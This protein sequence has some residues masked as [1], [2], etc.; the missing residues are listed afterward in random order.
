MPTIDKEMNSIITDSIQIISIS[1]IKV[2]SEAKKMV[3]FH[4]S[5]TESVLNAFTRV[6]HRRCQFRTVI[7]HIDSTKKNTQ[8]KQRTEH[9][10]ASFVSRSY[11]SVYTKKKLYA[12]MAKQPILKELEYFVGGATTAATISPSG[13]SHL[14]HCGLN[15]LHN[16]PASKDAV[17]E[18][19]TIFFD[20]AVA[21]YVK[22][23]EVR[24]HATMQFFDTIKFITQSNFRKKKQ[25]KNWPIFFETNFF[26]SVVHSKKIQ[27]LSPHMIAP[28][29][30]CKMHWKHCWIKDNMHGC[31][32]F[33]HGASK[34]WV[35]YQRNTSDQTTEVSTIII[36]LLTRNQNESKRNDFS[37]SITIEIIMQLY[38]LLYVMMVAGFNLISIYNFK[39]PSR[40]MLAS[41]PEKMLQTICSSI[42]IP[43]DMI[44]HLLHIVK[45]IQVI[46]CSLEICTLIYFRNEKTKMLSQNPYNMYETVFT[47][48]IITHTWV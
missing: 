20:A 26:V 38:K 33:R 2:L 6:Y 43:F 21:G 29:L 31:R 46:N 15:L 34:H 41:G 19:F 25:K 1:W 28:L 23:M 30:R 22:L 7:W 27:I 3:R 40:N 8:K 14:V 37:T 47:S 35:F 4:L 13:L 9:H 10:I 5:Q 32:T 48:E 39:I 42:S 12:I 17:F 18:Y 44:C 45:L 24:N 11:I 36:L 16:L